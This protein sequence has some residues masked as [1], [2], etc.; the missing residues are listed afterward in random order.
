MTTRMPHFDLRDI[1]V[2]T[3]ASWERF[4]NA[5]YTATTMSIQKQLFFAVGPKT[6]VHVAIN[7][8]E[9]ATHVI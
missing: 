5:S 3:I 6:L 1:D 2:A 7:I 9:Y 8:R 4:S